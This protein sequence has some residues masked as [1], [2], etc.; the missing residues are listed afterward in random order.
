MRKLEEQGYSAYMKRTF[1]FLC[2]LVLIAH[3]M[4]WMNYA[5]N[6]LNK[7]PYSRAEEMELVYKRYL[8]WADGLPLDLVRAG[9]SQHHVLLLQ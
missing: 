1:L 4:I 9:E 2:K 6:S 5:G 3:D 7:S 8:A